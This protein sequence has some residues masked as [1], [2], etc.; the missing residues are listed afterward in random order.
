MPYN[1]KIDNMKEQ[2]SR[3]HFF[4]LTG[5]SVFS[6]MFP[7]LLTAN[8]SKATKP[9]ILFIMLDDLGK[10]WI[11]CYGA[12]NIKTP[13]I[14]ALATT[15]MKFHNAY[16]MPQCT[17]SRVSLLT[18][19]YPWRTGWINLWDVPRNGIAYFDWKQPENMTFARM[20]KKAGYTT[21]AAGKWHVNDFRVEPQAMKKHGFDDW[22]MW[23]GYESNNRP[24]R[25]R[26]HHPYLNTPQGSKTYKNQFGPNI[27][28]DFLVDF[29]DK[30]RDKPMMMY[31]PMVLPHVPFINIPG[32]PKTKSFLQRHINMVE[33]VDSLVGQ[34]I[35]ALD[36]FGLR[37]NTIVFF[38]GDNGTTPKITGNINGHKIAG[39]KKTKL[40]SGVCTP[41]I[42]NCP[43][44]IPSKETHA[45]TD[46]TDMLPTFMELAGENIPP[47]PSIDGKSI[48][49]LLL[50]NNQDSGRDWIM[51]MGHGPA[52]VD[53]KGVRG[54]FDFASRVIRD[55]KHKVWV[56]KNRAIFR[57]HDLKSDPY[58]QKNLLNSHQPEHVAALKKFQAILD[59]MPEK[60]AR[61]KYT[62][63]KS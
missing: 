4:K 1:S 37:D 46:F 8:D 60:D 9:N 12:E 21:A 14:D 50:G 30:H 40:E 61:P 33:H 3:R 11:S 22:C 20:L 6:A 62:P 39:G 18:G 52:R 54:Q 56:N 24:S 42:V 25:R 27:F 35:S 41:F 63:R 28:A 49:P 2:Y 23:T 32:K 48:A 16:S 38:T 43:N 13:N 51:S 59:T 10:E 34:L 29:M 36:R 19:Q 31:Y 44:M 15:G 53:D 17:P 58:E 45:L 7:Q 26:Y 47:A 55:K 5:C 57:L